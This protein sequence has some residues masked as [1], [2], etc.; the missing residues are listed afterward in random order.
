MFT[1]TLLLALFVGVV[2][3]SQL[4]SSQSRSQSGLRINRAA[5]V[6][7]VAGP[8]VQVPPCPKGS[9]C[10]FK[11]YWAGISNQFCKGS[12]IRPTAINVCEWID[13]HCAPAGGDNVLVVDQ[14]EEIIDEDTG[15]NV[16]DP[17]NVCRARETCPEG[18][19]KECFNDVWCQCNSVGTGA[20][21]N[22]KFT[23]ETGC[24]GL[25]KKP[26]CKFTGGK[27]HFYD[28][29]PD[30]LSECDT[31]ICPTA[32]ANCNAGKKY[33]Q[34]VPP[35]S[36]EDTTL[37]GFCCGKYECV[38]DANY[39]APD[40]CVTTCEEGIY[41]EISPPTYSLDDADVLRCC[42][43]HEC[44]SMPK[45]PQEDC[46]ECTENCIQSLFET[47][48]DAFQAEQSTYCAVEENKEDKKMSGVCKM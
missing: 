32:S 45:E 41:T 25:E 11:N 22:Y 24:V 9:T 6:V 44:K 43:K 1:L 42:G 19:S 5:P 18:S 10:L 30:Q 31:S 34:I 28:G 7:P 3:S 8:S 39:C 21:K 4:R 14:P 35:G 16:N 12:T 38:D 40:L 37:I 15:E 33:S 47:S 48:A 13:A 27:C 23:S 26:H 36:A 2:P 46:E 17:K 20:N 29:P